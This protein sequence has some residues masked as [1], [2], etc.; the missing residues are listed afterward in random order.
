MSDVKRWDCFSEGMREGYGEQYVLTSDYDALRAEVER[1]RKGIEQWASECSNCGGTGLAVVVRGKLVDEEVCDECVDIRAL[2]SPALG[3]GTVPSAH[4]KCCC[5]EHYLAG[6][7]NP[8]S[9]MVDGRLHRRGKPC[10][11]PAQ[12]PALPEVKP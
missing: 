12:L 9:F 2:L 7:S 10:Y 3:E 4:E 1:L 6:R 5:G 8:E 11:V